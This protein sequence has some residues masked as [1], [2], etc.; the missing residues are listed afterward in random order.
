[1]SS[2]FNVTYGICVGND[3]QYLSTLRDSIEA[4]WEEAPSFAGNFE[5]IMADDATP[6]GWLPQKKNWI[7]DRARYDNLVI[8]H[9]YYLFDPFWLDYVA[10]W[11]RRW[12]DWDVMCCPIET[13]E[14]HRSA[15]WMV[16]PNHIDAAIKIYPELES[17]LRA[18]NPFENGARYV[19]ALPYNV[20]DL[21]NIQYISGGYIMCKRDLLQ[22]IPMDEALKSGDAEDVEWSQRVIRNHAKIVLNQLPTMKIQ[23]PNK[24]AV[25]QMPREAVEIMRTYNAGL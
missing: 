22:G 7:A 8:V 15:D 21:T 11:D 3:T 20:D 17:I 4:M 12:P 1:M 10:A 6:G 14:G 18:A 9:D 16:N 25:T 19:N 24:W 23:K 5:I 13:F 2:K